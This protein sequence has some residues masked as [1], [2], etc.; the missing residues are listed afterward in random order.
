MIQAI[1]E[2]RKCQTSLGGGAVYDLFHPV[3]AAECQ[4]VGDQFQA[5][6]QRL[7]TEINGK[8]GTEIV[9]DGQFIYDLFSKVRITRENANSIIIKIESMIQMLFAGVGGSK[10]GRSKLSSILDALQILFQSPIAQDTPLLRNY[11]ANIQCKSTIGQTQQGKFN[12]SGKETILSFWCF[13]P[14]IAM[15]N[16]MELSPR[17]VVLASGTLSPLNTL[18]EEFGMPFPNR[19]ENTHVIK[20]SQILVG[21]M[22][23]GPK[24][25]T[26]TSTFAQRDNMNYLSDLG[27][28]VLGICE[29]TPGGVLCFFTSYKVMTKALETWERGA[30]SA[31]ILSQITKIKRQFRESKSKEGFSAD[32][33]EYEKVINGG[34]GA[35]LFAVFR[36]KASEGID[37]SDDKARAVIICGI[38]FP[39]MNDAKVKLKKKILNDTGR[40]GQV[41]ILY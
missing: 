38:P 11:R 2:I 9:K 5:L 14:A 7:D 23:V 36:G 40:G 30:Q 28:T 19:I 33:T 20:Q 4:L 39:A 35:I 15:R 31:S 24:G 10:M 37:F 29:K 34:K 18:S 17:T 22:K 25:H 3:N 12:A 41:N 1:V 26:L 13:S 8:E 16:M 6:L 21:V 32:Y 27:L